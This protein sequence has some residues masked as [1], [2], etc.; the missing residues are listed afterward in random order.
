MGGASGMLN[1]ISASGL[2]IVEPRHE[3]EV[4]GNRGWGGNCVT[5]NCVRKLIYCESS[6]TLSLAFGLVCLSQL[7]ICL[8]PCVMS[9]FS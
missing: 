7:S 2:V 3:A 9:C 6:S 1:S 5:V 8:L 4:A